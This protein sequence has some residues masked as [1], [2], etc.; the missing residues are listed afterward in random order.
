MGL[1]RQAVV[2]L[3]QGYKTLKSYRFSCHDVI[4]AQLNVNVQVNALHHCRVP[5]IWLST[6]TRLRLRQPTRI[7]QPE[8]THPSV[9]SV[10]VPTS[11]LDVLILLVLNFLDVLSF[12]ILRFLRSP[13]GDQRPL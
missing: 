9:S 8:L 4:Q 2:N 13:G 3:F 1:C 12:C 10:Q 7:G 11:F 6:P 5:F